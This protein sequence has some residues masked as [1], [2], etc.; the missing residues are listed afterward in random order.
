MTGESAYLLTPGGR[1]VRSRTMPLLAMLSG[2]IFLPIL[3]GVMVVAG[4]TLESVVIVLLGL[5]IGGASFTGVTIGM[6]V[7][8]FKGLSKLREAQ[9]YLGQGNTTAARALAQWPLAWVFRADQR[10]R[11]FYTLGQCAELDGQFDDA[12]L[13]FQ[14]AIGSSPAFAVSRIRNH[15][16]AHASSHRAFALAAA[17]R[18]PEAK[19]ALG[20][21]HHAL[22]ALM[23]PQGTLGSL[24]DDSNWGMGAA[25]LNQTV[26]DMDNRD[27][28]AFA[29]LAGVV[30]AYRANEPQ[31]ALDVVSREGRALWSLLPHE[32][33]L[34][35]RVQTASQTALAQ[36]GAMRQEGMIAPEDPRI[37]RWVERALGHA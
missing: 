36:G 35:K 33:A 23:G 12:A 25:S 1:S 27:P 37:A 30:L 21:A 11:A 6:W 15:L 22:L 34:I 17:G 26:R 13:L 9:M 5:F 18:I 31:A 29:V 32:A 3:G 28:R 19:E 7:A 2:M 10:T 4:S 24:F 16:V 14:E 20:R 8:L